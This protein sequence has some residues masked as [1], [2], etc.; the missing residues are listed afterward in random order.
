[1]SAKPFKPEIKNCKDIKMDT[2]TALIVGDSG[3][4]K[5][6]LLGTLPPDSLIISLEKGLLSLKGGDIPYIQIP[7]GLDPKAKLDWLKSSMMWASQQPYK[8]IAIDSITEMS[9][10]L[11]DF[12]K[13]LYP[14]DN[15][16][17]K[18]Y[19]QHKEQLTS[20]IKYCRDMNKNIFFTSLVKVDKDEIGRK[21]NL[22]AVAG[23]LSEE[24]PKYF[25]F[26]FY[27]EVFEKDGEK[28]RA[29]LTDKKPDNK[30]KDRSGKLDE[31]EKPDLSNIINK[32][33]GEL[34]NV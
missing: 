7:E 28:K 22:P 1:M 30:A 11:V 14:A 3:A 4:G 5:T 34:T 17:F 18:V 32:V 6:K 25:D 8:N 33:N 9:E 24:L 15:Q 12:G 10:F 16:V 2:I 29:I 21:V 23:S 13:I 20:S 26:V 19:G 27:L 31:W